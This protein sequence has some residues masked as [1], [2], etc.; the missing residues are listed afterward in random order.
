VEHRD[1]LVVMMTVSTKSPKATQ[2]NGRLELPHKAQRM[3][4]D[5]R[6]LHLQ[7]D[8]ASW[9]VLSFSNVCLLKFGIF[10]DVRG[11]DAYQRLSAI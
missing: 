11:A 2:V 10:G 1:I 6:S 4:E 8:I 3:R 9:V 7:L 5:A